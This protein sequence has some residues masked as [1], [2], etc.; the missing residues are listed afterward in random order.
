MT[1]E[2]DG[3]ILNIP[4]FE[5]KA[6]EIYNSS[7]EYL[8]PEVILSVKIEYKFGWIFEESVQIF[9]NF[10][11]FIVVSGVIIICANHT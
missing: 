8:G 3:W 5:Q 10:D 4:L 1:K 9:I 2:F 7:R 6:A 11:N